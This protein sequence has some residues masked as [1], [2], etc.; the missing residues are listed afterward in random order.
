[1]RVRVPEQPPTKHEIDNLLE[2]GTQADDDRGIVARLRTSCYLNYQNRRVTAQ[3]RLLTQYKRDGLVLFLGAGVSCDSGI[4]NWNRLAERV[5]YRVGIDDYDSIKVTFPSLI[6][7]FEVAAQRSDSR[8]KFARA[9]YCSLYRDLKFKTLLMNI[10]KSEKDRQEKEQSQIWGRHSWR[11]ILA[12]LRTNKTLAAVGELLVVDGRENLRRNPQVHAVI[13]TNAD[14]LLQIYCR[15]RA[16]GERRI[17]T[18]VDRA[19]VGDHP[20]SISVYHLHGHLDARGENIVRRS[21]CD[22]KQRVQ[23]VDGELLPDLVFRESEYYDTIANSANFVNHIPQ[24]YLQRLNVLFIG[25]SLE[26]LNVRRWL[27]NSFQERRNQRA[28]YLAEYYCLP[29]KDAYYEAEVESVRHF[30]IRT[31]PD[32]EHLTKLIESN[33]RD[34]GIQVVWCNDYSAIQHCLHDLNEKGRVADF[35]R[36]FS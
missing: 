8:L 7:Q 6:T 27:H 9:L 22:T 4:P 36:R 28:R 34:L 11:R 15:A 29:Y 35:G 5:L 3:E 33:V 31:P 16:D 20:D 23:A 30:W 21:P 17:V 19:S 10:P 13:T 18:T 26:D 2:R 1:M 25:T 12:H 32:K 14:N 24:S